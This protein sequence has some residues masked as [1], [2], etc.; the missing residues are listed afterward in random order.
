MKK[1]VNMLSGPIMKG[2][3]TISLPVMVMNVVQSLFN[4]VDM[5]V[6][7]TFDSSGGMAVGAVGTCSTLISL[8]TG[9]LIGTAAGANVV[10]AKHIGAGDKDGVERAV[11]TSVVFSVLGGAALAIIGVIFGKTFLTWTNCPES[12]LEQATLY[13]RLYFAG[14]P[15]LMLYN[16]CAAILRSTGDSK[17]PMIFLLSGGVVKIACNLLFVAVCKWE[18]LGVALATILSWSF[19]AALAM[20]ALLKTDSI[21]RI[22]RRHLRLYKAELKEILSIGLPAGLQQSMYAIANVIISATVN[23]FGAAATT[24]I[25][26]ANTFDNI[27][28]QIA[29]AP[30]LAVMPYVSQNIGNHNVPRAKK[31]VFDGVMLSLILSGSIG[32]LSAIFSGP[33]S[34]IMSSNPEVIA[35]SQQK[36][37]I[38][39]STYFICGINNTLDAALRGMGKPMVPTVL[40]LIYLCALR[41]IWVYF[42]FPLYPTLT[43]LYL[44]WPIGWTLQLVTLLIFYF[45]TVK[46]QTLKH[47]KFAPKPE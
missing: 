16:F 5:T 47:A 18:V 9:L 31:A 22:K 32:A 8:I 23:T 21:I 14:S 38:I 39:S 4:I 42:I 3:L 36:M 37:L 30:S 40:A 33:L 29:H 43:F 41:F 24:G 25:S 12:L 34:S 27:I 1:E 13:F 46:W 28:Y 6:L 11:G 20:I 10:I 7:K 17:R 2:L 19:S 44:V 26:I 15:L 45:P 35:Y